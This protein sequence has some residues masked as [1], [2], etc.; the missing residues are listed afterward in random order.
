MI[1]LISPIDG[2]Y[3]NKTEELWDYFSEY[4]LIKYRVYVEIEFLKFLLSY[5]EIW[6]SLSADE[7]KK[8]DKIY[9]S[10][11]EKDALE[12]KEIEKETNHDVKAVEYFLKK[13]IKNI[14][15]NALEFVHF[16]CTS[17]DINNLAYS[18]MLKDWV[19]K[20]II[21]S[22][23]SLIQTLG[24]LAKKWANVSLLSRTHWQ[25]AS[26]TTVWKEFK[27]FEVRLKRQMEQI[28]NQKFYWKL[29]WATWN[30]NAHFAAF[31]NIDWIR[32]SKTFIKKLWLEP[33]MFTCQIEPH[34]FLAEIFDSWARVSTILIDFNR[35]IWS[36]ISFWFFGQKLKAWEI[37]SS[38]MPHKV[39]PIDFENSEGN[40]G[41]AISIFWHLAR[42]LPISRMQRDLTDSTV[43]R[44]IW[45]GFAY[46]LIAIKSSDKWIWKLE[47]NKDIIDKDL[48]SNQ[49]V[50]AEAIQTVM[51]KNWIKNPYEKLKELTRWKRL[52]SEAIRLFIENQ[53]LPK[54]DKQILLSLSPNSY[55]WIAEKI[56]GMKL[57][58]W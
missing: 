36:Y 52:S 32:F 33:N 50:L 26:P 34:D 2:R 29:N 58:D 22:S 20:V 53:N 48:E 15:K 54:S 14:N 6:V 25:T 30:F 13:K 38:A 31:P 55:V 27:V 46:L 49:E 12:I 19:W 40:L 7:I 41:L 10:F 47:L 3:W 35:D 39:N 18:L 43:L 56:A 45:V 24:L 4:A 57:S 5:K 8:I 11:S 44:N 23:E 21:P 1:K 42:K 51:R 17:E 28:K 16:A 9:L 37:W